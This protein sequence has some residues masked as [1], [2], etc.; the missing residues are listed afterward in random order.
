MSMQDSLKIIPLKQNFGDVAI[1][2]FDL[3]GEKANKLNTP[4]MNRLK[5]CLSE[6]AKSSYKVVILRSAKAKI[7]IAGADIDEIKSMTTKEQF[8]K[9][10]GDE[11]LIANIAWN[12]AS[13]YNDQEQY[14]LAAKYM[15]IMVDFEKKINHPNIT[16]DIE[17][18][19]E[20]L[21][22]AD[23]TKKHREKN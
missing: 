3:F 13:V 14:D 21:V 18:L 6:L 4:V 23:K 11:E 22:K 12:L 20:V 16:A 9:A 19:K 10:V 8:A 7:F 17:L 5:E 2:E 15:Q 1:L